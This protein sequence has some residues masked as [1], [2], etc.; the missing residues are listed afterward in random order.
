MPDANSANSTNSTNSTNSSKRC[1]SID[2]GI[3]NL[4]VCLLKGPETIEFWEVFDL[5]TSTG[6]TRRLVKLCQTLEAVPQLWESVDTVLIE[7]QPSFNPRMRVMADALHMFF[8]TKGLR[9][10][11]PYSAKYKLQLCKPETEYQKGTKYSKNKKRAIDT[12]KWY[13]ETVNSLSKWSST[14]SKAKKKDDF[15]D[16]FLQGVS[17]Y[18]VY[19]S[20]TR[21]MKKP[22]VK[23][24]ESGKLTESH[25]AWLW[26]TWSQEYLT[27]SQV[28][29]PMDRHLTT[30]SE[31]SNTIIAYIESKLKTSKNIEKYV[32]QLYGSV[33]DYVENME[34]PCESLE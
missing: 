15:A 32:K 19:L 21:E 10:I 3:K 18:K 6:T 2:V 25:F 26:T 24:L 13:L 20:T 4:A 28:L 11:R 17:F 1:L 22:T 31:N 27:N 23:T 29:G 12:T 16:S 33:A 14:F 34:S 8:V 5:G 7:K 30:D 9:D